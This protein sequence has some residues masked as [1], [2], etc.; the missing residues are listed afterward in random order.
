MTDA[1][2]TID[3][4]PSDMPESEGTIAAEKWRRTAQ[5]TLEGKVT[6]DFLC[7]FGLQK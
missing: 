4:Q 6:C 5:T 1:A 3:A 7:E 2:D